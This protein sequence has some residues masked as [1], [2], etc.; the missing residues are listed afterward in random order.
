LD[1][2]TI[3]AVVW[4]GQGRRLRQYRCKHQKFLLSL[5][6]VPK[7]ADTMTFD[8][9]AAKWVKPKPKRVLGK[10]WISKGTWRLIMKRAS[11]LQSGRIWQDATRRMKWKIGATIKVDK[12]KLIANIGNLII[13]ELSKGDIKEAFW[14]LKG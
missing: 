5:L 11:L 14:H 12:C 2:R 7:D 6:P 13:A 4:A 10:D 9:K 8:A 3:I 1:H